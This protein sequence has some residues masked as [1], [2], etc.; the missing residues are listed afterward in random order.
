MAAELAP[1]IHGNRDCPICDAG[2]LAPVSRD[3]PRPVGT[4]SG[5]ERV[6]PQVLAAANATPRA[7]A[8]RYGPTADQLHTLRT[9][10]E[11][12]HRRGRV[13]DAFRRTV[14]NVLTEVYRAG[15]AEERAEHDTLIQAEGETRKAALSASLV[16]MLRAD[17]ALYERVIDTPGFANHFN[18]ICN[19]AKAARFPLPGG[20]PE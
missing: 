14:E 19:M 9:A 11:N 1:C 8:V 13:P 6:T 17:K 5:P 2:Y 20:E 16:A 18:A 10:F 4:I 7:E 12:E 15:L 3:T